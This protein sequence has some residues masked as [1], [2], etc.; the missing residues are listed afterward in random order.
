MTQ[1]LGYLDL[2]DR[3]VR[4][5]DLNHY[6]K[7]LPILQQG[8]LTVLWD[9][10]QPTVRSDG[11]PQDRDN[12]HLRRLLAHHVR[13]NNTYLEGGEAMGGEDGITVDF[14]REPVDTITVKLQA[15]H[16]RR[17][18]RSCVVVDHPRKNQYYA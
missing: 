11:M 12:R 2:Y 4:F 10:P 9:H 14:M 3:F 6:H 13:M 15:L 16:L 5:K 18:R 8:G 1:P 17:T 7:L